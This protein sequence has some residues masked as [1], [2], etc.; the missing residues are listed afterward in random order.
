L[1]LLNAFGWPGGLALT[2]AF[3]LNRRY[4]CEVRR[5]Y[6]TRFG[7]DAASFA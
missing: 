1:A 2:A 4:R 3:S 6:L 5:M 7:L